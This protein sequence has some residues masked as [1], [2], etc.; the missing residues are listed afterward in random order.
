MLVAGVVREGVTVGEGDGTRGRDHVHT[1]GVS[2]DGGPRQ[3]R[4]RLRTTSG[5]SND[6]GRGDIDYGAHANGGKDDIR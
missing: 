2:N 3:R 1:S 5:L 6:S 4:Q